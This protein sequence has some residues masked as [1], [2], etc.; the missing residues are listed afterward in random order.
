[1]GRPKIPPPQPPP[2]PPAARPQRNVE[3][4]T[5]DIQLGGVAE[6][7]KK[8]PSMAGKRALIRPRGGS[9]TT[10]SASSGLKV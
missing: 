6:A 7:A 8:D 2:P 5:D 1:M 3:V 10:S 9:V 4:E